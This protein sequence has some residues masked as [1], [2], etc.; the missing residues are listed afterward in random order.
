MRTYLFAIVTVVEVMDFDYQY[1]DV[2]LLYLWAFKT[3]E[4]QLID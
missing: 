2:Y 1:L 4:L 3:M